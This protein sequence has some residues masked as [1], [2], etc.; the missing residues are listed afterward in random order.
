MYFLFLSKDYFCGFVTWI[1]ICCSGSVLCK[2]S[3]IYTTAFCV[4]NCYFIETLSNP[5]QEPI[6][7]EQ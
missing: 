4:E 6:S 7:A 2:Y 3:I 5:F 1:L